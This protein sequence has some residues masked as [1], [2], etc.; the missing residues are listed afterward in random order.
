MILETSLNVIKRLRPPEFPRNF[1]LA[2]N[3]YT[4]SNYLK[5][6]CFFCVSKLNKRG[7]R[8]PHYP[9]EL[10]CMLLVSAILFSYIYISFVGLYCPS[11]VGPG[12]L[13][14]CLRK[15]HRFG[16]TAYIYIYILFVWWPVDECTPHINTNLRGRLR[17]HHQHHLCPAAALCLSFYIRPHHLIICSHTQPDTRTF[18]PTR[19]LVKIYTR[20][21]TQQIN[22]DVWRVHPHTKHALLPKTFGRWVAV[23]KKMSAAHNV[24][25]FHRDISSSQCV[26]PSPKFVGQLRRMARNE[27][28]RKSFEMPFNRNGNAAAARERI[29]KDPPPSA[30]VRAPARII[31]SW[32]RHAVGRAR[33][34]MIPEYN[35]QT[36]NNK[37]GCL[38]WWEIC[39]KY[40]G[41]QA[42][43]FRW[44]TWCF[45]SVGYAIRFAYSRV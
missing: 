40:I 3:T 6:Q 34:P 21:K 14:V 27:S 30:C 10:P 39:K 17:N 13:W 20:I 28:I 19:H 37:M 33:I 9:G 45:Y 8:S 29:V 18:D 22:L 41:L 12:A 16:K 24:S 2:Q 36:Y 32:I 31:P 1:R 38:I 23:S 4:Q 42:H 7:P 44:W 26:Y 43:Y 5:S 15:D 25:S 35:N 11:M